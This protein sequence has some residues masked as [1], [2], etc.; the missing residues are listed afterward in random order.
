MEQSYKDYCINTVKGDGFKLEFLCPEAKNDRDVVLAAIKENSFS[1]KFASDELKN[2][3]TIVT[4]AVIHN[5]CNI[6]YASNEIRSDISFL[7]DLA[8]QLTLDSKQYNDFL[9]ALDVEIINK[10]SK[11]RF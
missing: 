3:K 8:N 10:I 5:G 4:I 6:A 9:S 7:I 1:F 11:K 2:D